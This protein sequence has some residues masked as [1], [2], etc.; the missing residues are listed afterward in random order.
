MQKYTSVIVLTNVFFMLTKIKK[1]NLPISVVV[2]H[3]HTKLFAII[4]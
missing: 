2:N 1:Y 3:R 4:K